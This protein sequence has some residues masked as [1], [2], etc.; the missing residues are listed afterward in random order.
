MFNPNQVRIETNYEFRSDLIGLQSDIEAKSNIVVNNFLEF[1]AYFESGRWSDSELNQIATQLEETGKYFAQLQGF[2]AGSSSRI[3]FNGEEYI[4]A[5][6]TKFNTGNL[7][8]HI[9]A[10][11]RG[12]FVK[13]YNDATNSRNQPYAGHM[14]YGFHD[15]GGNFIPGRPFMRP[16]FYAV[17]QASKGRLTSILK[18]L[19][20]RTWK[21]DGFSGISNIDF[22]RRDIFYSKDYS[23]VR[24]MKNFY[25][26]GSRRRLKQVRSDKFR[27]DLS[28]KRGQKRNS[29]EAR[30]ASVKKDSRVN[31]R[32]NQG[33]LLKKERRYKMRKDEYG[34]HNPQ[35]YKGGS[36]YTQDTN[37][38][39]KN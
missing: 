22:G 2:G 29:K 5:R 6:G 14:E 1:S 18:G 10:E 11:R 32:N 3:N 20:E 35:G 31:V 15:R 4:S 7:V 12:T 39:K 26:R 28:A 19:L 37:R 30:T 16:A 34:W 9:K 27:R 33:H 25:G 21:G 13:F 17:S 36:K 23:V 24:K 8:N 38:A